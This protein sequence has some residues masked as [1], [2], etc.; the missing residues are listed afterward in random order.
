MV[1]KLQSL[2]DVQRCSEAAAKHAHGQATAARM[3][4]EEEQIRL[5]RLREAA[6]CALEGEKARPDNARG[7]G[8][9]EDGNWREQ[10]RQRLR[11]E[12]VRADKAAALHRATSLASAWKAEEEASARCDKLRQEREATEKLKLRALAKEKKVALRRG[13]AAASDLAVTAF[14]RRKREE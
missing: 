2:L 12:L 5:D 8:R 6:G 14:A 9:V 4:E 1:F 10:Y 11:A 7:P 3:R 13:E